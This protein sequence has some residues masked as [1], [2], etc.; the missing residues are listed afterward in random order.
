MDTRMSD[1]SLYTVFN[2]VRS[3]EVIKRTER[4]RTAVRRIDVLHHSAQPLSSLLGYFS[5][6]LTRI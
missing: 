4:S 3:G 5:Y 6:T 1:S 2:A